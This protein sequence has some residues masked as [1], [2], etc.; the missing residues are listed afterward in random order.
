MPVTLCDDNRHAVDSDAAIYGRRLTWRSGSVPTVV[1]SYIPISH[2]IFWDAAYLRHTADAAIC[3]ATMPSFSAICLYLL[4]CLANCRATPPGV[5]PFCYLRT[6]AAAHTH[7]PHDV[8]RCCCNTRSAYYHGAL[9]HRR[10]THLL[11]GAAKTPALGT[12]WALIQTRAA[13]IMRAVE[14]DLF[15]AAGTSLSGDRPPR[16]A[17]LL[18]RQAGSGWADEIQM[19][20]LSFSLSRPCALSLLCTNMNC[21]PSLR[22]VVPAC[23]PPPATTCLPARALP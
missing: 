11:P 14:E 10:G 6:A 21:L 15:A 8:K 4:C 17:H 13:G 20:Y 16:S 5:L 18:A 2:R 3:S 23:P 1:S 7:L 19:L 12:C 9:H 22:T